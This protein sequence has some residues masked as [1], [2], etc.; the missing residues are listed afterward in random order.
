MEPA[1]TTNERELGALIAKVELLE[2]QMESQGRTLNE[3]RDAIVKAKGG[4][5]TLIA[6]GTIASGI[7]TFIYKMVPH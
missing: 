6:V 5:W 7:T 3:V 1:M 4:W 2:K